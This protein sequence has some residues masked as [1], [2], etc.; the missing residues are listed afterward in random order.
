MDFASIG[1]QPIES[2]LELDMPRWTF[3]TDND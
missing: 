3:R 1:T 2:P